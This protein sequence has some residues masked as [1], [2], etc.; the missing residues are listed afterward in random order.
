MV[1]YLRVHDGCRNGNT[2]DARTHRMLLCGERAR[3]LE[4]QRVGAVLVRESRTTYNAT[5]L[6]PLIASCS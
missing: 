3:N 4:R 2:R 5:K 1:S 6:P